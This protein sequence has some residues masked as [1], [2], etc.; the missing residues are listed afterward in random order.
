MIG[1]VVLGMHRSGTSAV[2]RAVN[3]L[4]AA[5]GDVRD[6]MPPRED[7]PSGFWESA[8]L[9]ALNDE[10][11]EALDAQWSAP[12]SPRA[13]REGLA[14]LSC[15]RERAGEALRAVF[16]A[17]RSV[18]KD[19]RLSITLPFWLPLLEPAPVFILTHRNPLEI[20]AS[21]A[22]RNGFSKALSLALWERYVRSALEHVQGRAAF[23]VRFTDLLE[24]RARCLAELRSFL[25]RH[26]AAA[27]LDASVEESAG[28]IDPRLRHHVRA[29]ASFAN[30]HDASPE[31][32]DLHGVLE[33]IAGSHDRLGVPRPPGETPWA[34]EIIEERRR[35]LRQER[36]GAA[37]AEA[38]RGRSDRLQQQLD[39]L[40][41]CSAEEVRRLSTLIGERDDLIAEQEARL[42]RLR[43]GLPGRL[44]RWILAS[45]VRRR[46]S[47]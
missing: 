37:D 8:S 22:V 3:L 40:R 24:D 17:P 44:A 23:V 34:T 14:R 38:E 11:L 9:T 15:F 18:W 33:R 5:L 43:Q 19:P 25:V 35:R 2:T 29:A 30:D 16:P 21:L 45:H 32:K 41:R 4:G 47:G 6:R 26:D 28:D 27:G 36:L 7:N 1:V 42:R 10:L 39:D 20:A 12:V 13:L 31:Q 46:H